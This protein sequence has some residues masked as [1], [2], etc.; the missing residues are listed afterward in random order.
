MNV[1]RQY[2]YA[3]LSPEWPWPQR[4]LAC[5]GDF[6]AGKLVSGDKCYPCQTTKVH[7]RM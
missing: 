3:M 1:C 6:D 5:N 2:G 4:V 7:P